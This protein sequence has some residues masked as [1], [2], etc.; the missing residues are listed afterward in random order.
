[1]ARS[2]LAAA[3]YLIVITVRSGI[4]VETVAPPHPNYVA[5][6]NSPYE[7]IAAYRKRLN[8]TY[9]YIPQHISA[10]H[11]QFLTEEECERD[12]MAAYAR[13]SDNSLERRL[14]GDSTYVSQGQVKVL[15]L[16]LRFKDH[17]SK[18]LPD[19]DYYDQ[20]FNGGAVNPVGGLKEWLFTNSAGKY[21]GRRII[22]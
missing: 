12:D 15:V 7:S 14:Q 3:L 22:G 16:L 19:R 13:M 4:L 5:H 9:N 1:M 20:L 17:A 21:D 11:C 18:E 10:R 6:T 2:R 8:I